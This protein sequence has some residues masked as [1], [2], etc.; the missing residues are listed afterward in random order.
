ME[1]LISCT[2]HAMDHMVT[3]ENQDVTVLSL[4]VDI[5]YSGPDPVAK[6]S[7]LCRMD[8]WFWTWA[9]GYHH[10]T[11]HGTTGRVYEDIPFLDGKIWAIHPDDCVNCKYEKQSS[12]EDPCYRC[13]E[14]SEYVFEEEVR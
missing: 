5:D 1:N 11:V 6:F 10:E 9:Q 3:L 12:S 13:Y 14:G 4:T 7:I 2:K 8:E